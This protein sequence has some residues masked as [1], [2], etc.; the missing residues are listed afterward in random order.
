MFPEPALPGTHYRWELSGPHPR[1]TESEN[2]W[3]GEGTVEVEQSALFQASMGA[4]AS[5]QVQ[6]QLHSIPASGFRV[7][8]TLT[9]SPESVRFEVTCLWADV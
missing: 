3:W 1:S 4:N 2:P 9:N 8:A 6:E 5:V 7:E